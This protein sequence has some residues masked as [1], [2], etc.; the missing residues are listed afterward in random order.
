MSARGRLALLRELLLGRLKPSELLNDRIFSCT[1][2]EA[3]MS[4]CPSGVDITE[5]IYHGR[6][7]LRQN[8][9]K[10]RLLRM[11]IKLFSRNPDL[12][13][14]IMQTFQFMLSPYFSKKGLVPQRFSL[15]EDTFK[16]G[17]QVYKTA[18]T[19]GRVAVF[20]GCST[21]FIYPHLGRSLVNVLLK[22]GYEVIVPSGEV[23]CGSPMRTLGLEGKAIESAERNM[24]IFGNLK[25]E[26][27]LSL[28]PTCIL[29]IKK[30]YPKLIGKGMENAMDVSSFLLDRLE[31]KQPSLFD[32]RMEK[33]AYH[34]PCH[35]IYGL[36]IRE[37]PRELLKKIRVNVIDEK[38]S[39]CCG[40]GGLFSLSYK[41]I[42]NSLL[43]ERMDYYSKAGAEAIITS[44]P[45][46]MLQFSK[47]SDKLP[48]FHIVELIEEAYCGGDE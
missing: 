6:S 11:L 40:F 14:K 35:L 33:A 8:D 28:C 44:C 29:T 31:L 46:C 34:D 5:D 30:Q 22:A 16:N 41:D 2:C 27:V 1:L 48:V 19:R 17:Q 25:V 47:K 37:E 45:G 3:C 7:I 18:E 21:N 26:A 24:R 12:N 32:P 42:S 4:L 9:K 13:F 36:G 15:P 20:A 38:K 10:R 23:C 43:Q 39:G